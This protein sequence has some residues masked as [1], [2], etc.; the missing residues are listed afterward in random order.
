ML[1]SPV[2][3]LTLELGARCY[4][5]AV[6]SRR[7]PGTDG[8]RHGVISQIRQGTIVVLIKTVAKGLV[9]S[10]LAATAA[11]ASMARP[12]TVIQNY[13]TV[14]VAAPEIDPASAFS[15]LMFLVGSLAV[16]RGRRAGK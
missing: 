10:L 2:I 16:I 6:V 13:S 7:P 12:L 14:P 15:G 8:N 11:H 5:P 4:D 3:V 9:L 1:V